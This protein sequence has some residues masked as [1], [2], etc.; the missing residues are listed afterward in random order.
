MFCALLTF[1]FLPDFPDKNRFLTREQTD[2]VLKRVELD[3]GD[4]VPD[5][6]TF[7]RVKEVLGDWVIWAHGASNW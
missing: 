6:I 7:V 2:L 1:L 4:S 3:R 5:D